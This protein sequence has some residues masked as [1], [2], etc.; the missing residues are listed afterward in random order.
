VYTALHKNSSALDQLNFLYDS[1]LISFDKRLQ[2]A[3]FN[4]YAG[5]FTIANALLNKADSI[6]PYVLPEIYNLYGLSNMLANKSKEA[7][8]FY[9]N[10]IKQVEEDKRK[11]TAYTLASLYA[12]TGNNREAIQ[13]LETA[14]GYGFNYS[15]VLL[16]DPLMDKLRN[17]QK[18]KTLV[19]SIAMKEYGKALN[20]TDGDGL[21]K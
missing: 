8:P 17:T 9:E 16:N 5:N 3:R 20:Y 10:N 14:I 4:I 15:F 1:S 21:N 12:E 7:I 13:W 6:H 19:G 18:W 2:L 11:F